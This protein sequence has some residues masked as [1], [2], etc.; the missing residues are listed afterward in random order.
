MDKDTE[1][2]SMF[3]ITAR[4]GGLIC[5]EIYRTKSEAETK[6]EKMKTNYS[7]YMEVKELEVLPFE[8]SPSPNQSPLCT[9]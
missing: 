4:G 2:K 5:S 1:K 8:E 6:I 7:E 9:T 3:A